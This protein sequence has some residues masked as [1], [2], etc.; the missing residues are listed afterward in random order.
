[1]AIVE[2]IQVERSLSDAFS[3]KFG[4][5]GGLSHPRPTVP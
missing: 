5:N 3:G 2:K 4:H 1:L